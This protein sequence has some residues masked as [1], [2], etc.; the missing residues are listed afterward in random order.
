MRPTPPTTS[1]RIDDPIELLLACHEKVH[2]FTALSL[3]L[4]AHVETRG[5][6][7]QAA[8]AALAILRYFDVAAPLHHADEDLDLY[9]ALITLGDAVLSEA[10]Q[11]IQ[12]EHAELSSLWQASRTWLIRVSEGQASAPPPDLTTF[13][14]AYERH[15]AEEEASLF[16][17]AQRLS[18]PQRQVICTA[19]VARRTA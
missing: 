12:A 1:P 15:A 4:Q 19:M 13:A 18:E 16:P 3:K 17:Q 2:R 11:R 5:A 14:A 7:A 9:P 6:D 8:E 10:I